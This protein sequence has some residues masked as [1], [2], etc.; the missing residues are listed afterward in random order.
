MFP[1]GERS[2]GH[3]LADAGGLLR[4]RHPD[5]PLRRARPRLA[6]QV[7]RAAPARPASHRGTALR[8]SADHAGL[9]G[10]PRPAR[11][12]DRPQGSQRVSA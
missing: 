7:R 2:A 8:Q 1:G 3:K 11:P 5:S 9:P 10:V 6:L 12:A 4:C